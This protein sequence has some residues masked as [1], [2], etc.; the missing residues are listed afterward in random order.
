[1]P[2]VPFR[3]A[4]AMEVGYVE[5][6]KIDGNEVFGKNRDTNKQIGPVLVDP[7]IAKL[8]DVGDTI[9]MISIRKHKNANFYE[10]CELG[11]VYPKEY[12]ENAH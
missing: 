5:V 6:T 10:I 9:N 1:M 3:F 4:D 8:M 7:E 11:Y 2:V 12:I